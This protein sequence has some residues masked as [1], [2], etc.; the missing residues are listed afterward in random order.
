MTQ[1]DFLEAGLAQP[2]Q[3]RVPGQVYNPYRFDPDTPQQR[4]PLAYVPFSAGPR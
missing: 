3:Q 2:H 4:S 1:E